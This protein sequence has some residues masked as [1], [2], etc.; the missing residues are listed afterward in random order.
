MSREVA[1]VPFHDIDILTIKEGGEIYVAMKDVCDGIGIEWKRQLKKITAHPALGL[2]SLIC[3]PQVPGDNQQREILTL[4]IQY[5]S[6]WLMLINPAKVKAPIRESLFDY[7]RECF[8]AL[9]NYWTK[10]VAVNTRKVAEI[11]SLGDY[12]ARLRVEIGELHNPAVRANLYAQMRDINDALG[13]P[14]EDI[15]HYTR[16]IE[17]SSNVIDLFEFYRILCT[18]HDVNHSSDPNVIAIEPESF[19][20]LCRRVLQEALPI[21]ELGRQVKESIEHPYIASDFITS[22]ITGKTVY[23]WMFGTKKP[24]FPEAKSLTNLHS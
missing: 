5:L 15:E 22:C 9:H 23:C 8:N 17:S 4:P 21:A 10:G 3:T 24:P 2:A 18:K 7:Q 14:T 11:V 19:N 1:R 20:E 6:G 12:A 13:Y 16:Q